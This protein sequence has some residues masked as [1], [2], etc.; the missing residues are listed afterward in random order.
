[1]GK[2]EVKLHF[3]ASESISSEEC[4]KITIDPHA[5]LEEAK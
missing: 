3:P 1:M 4:Q 2:D 5:D